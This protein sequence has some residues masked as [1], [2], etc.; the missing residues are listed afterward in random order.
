VKQQLL[1]KQMDDYVEDAKK[2]E[3]QAAQAHRDD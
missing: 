3:E 1:L 2:E